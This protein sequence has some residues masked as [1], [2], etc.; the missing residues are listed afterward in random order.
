MRQ[1]FKTRS[2]LSLST[3][4]LLAAIGLVG[5]LTGCGGG[6]SVGCDFRE[7]MINGIRCQQRDG[8][9]SYGFAQ[10]CEVAGGTPIDGPCPDEGKV[11]GCVSDSTEDVTDWYYE[12]MSLEQIE[13]ECQN[14]G[15]LIDP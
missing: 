4:G 12:P 2:T 3:G 5:A 10:A 9:Q 1:L 6:T 11:K 7:E 8:I 14:D 13:I 15:T